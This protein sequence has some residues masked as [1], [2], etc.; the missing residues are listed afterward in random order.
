M[1]QGSVCNAAGTL[2]ITALHLITLLYDTIDYA[3]ALVCV[4]V[5]GIRIISHCRSVFLTTAYPAM[6]I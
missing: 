2:T 6:Q 3:S 1:Q 5:W 4:C